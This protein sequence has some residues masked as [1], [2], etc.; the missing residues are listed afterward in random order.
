MMSDVST[1]T[2]G[3]NMVIL[4]FVWF[5]MG[6]K[7][8]AEDVNAAV[9]INDYKIVAVEISRGLLGLRWLCLAVLEKN[10]EAELFNKHSEEDRQNV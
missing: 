9:R 10:R 1:F 2:H 5:W 4:R 3:N 8:F 7:A 6:T